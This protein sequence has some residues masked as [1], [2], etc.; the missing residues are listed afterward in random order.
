MYF[1]HNKQEGEHSG[2]QK[3]PYFKLHRI[4]QNH[5]NPYHPLLL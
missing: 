1:K 4:M 3:P 5:S 2:L